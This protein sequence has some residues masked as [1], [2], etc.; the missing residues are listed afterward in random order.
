MQSPQEYIPNPDFYLLPY[1]PSASVRCLY[2]D[3]SL[4]TSPWGECYALLNPIHIPPAYKTSSNF[5]IAKLLQKN[6]P[7]SPFPNASR[8]IKYFLPLVLVVRYAKLLWQMATSFVA[9]DNITMLFYSFVGQEFDTGAHVA[10]TKVSAGILFLCIGIPFS[11]SFRCG[12][13]SL[14]CSGRMGVIFLPG[15]GW[16]QP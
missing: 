7:P 3:C 14:W 10:K 2:S 4:W 1:S 15:I 9:S 12:R 11:C 16:R 5:I 8:R 13:D 6:I